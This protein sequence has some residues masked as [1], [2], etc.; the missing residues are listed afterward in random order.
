MV[1]LTIVAQQNGETIYFEEPIPKVHFMKLISCSLFNSWY[2]LKREGSATL[3]DKGKDKAVSISK[4]VPGH[5]SLERM[6]KE[7]G[8]MFSKYN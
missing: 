6:A 8:G 2:N 7:I 4:I 3:G 5:Y 1:V